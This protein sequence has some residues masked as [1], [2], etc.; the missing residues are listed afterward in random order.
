MARRAL[1]SAADML[2]WSHLLDSGLLV[3][4]DQQLLAGYWLAVPDAENRTDE[5]ADALSDHI[6]A[7]MTAFGTGWA[8]WSDALC[9]PSSAY[10]PAWLSHFPDGFS[11]A[12]DAARRR[13]FEAADAHYETARVLLI[14]YT[15]PREQVSKLGDLFFTG[16]P[17]QAPVQ[18]RIVQHFNGMLEKFENRVG[19]AIGMQR[20]RTIAVED[21]LGHPGRQDELVNY[22]SYCATGRVQGVLLPR[23]GA[24]MDLLIASQEVT[25]GENPLIGRDVVAAVSI[26]GFPAESQPNILAALGNLGFP[27][28][29]SQRFIYLDTKHAVDAI[30]KYRDRW[31]QKMRGLGA[32]IMQNPDAPVNEHAA[33]MKAQA[34]A[35][36]AWAESGMVKYG[37]YSP[38]VI[39]RHP[40]H[41]VL[42]EWTT[43]IEQAM[44]S[45]GFGARTET[46][47]TIEAWRGALPGETYCNVV[48]LP[49]HTKNAADLLPLSAIWSGYETA[50]SPLYPKGAPAL[51]WADAGV[52]PFRFNLPIGP[53]GDTAHTLTMGPTGAGKTVLHNLI[54]VQARRYRGMRITGFD[55]KRGMMATVLACGG[56]H[57]DL[58]DDSRRDGLFCPLGV[59]ETEADLEWAT[60][61][62]AVLYELHTDHPPGPDL[63]PQ[64]FEA[65]QSLANLHPRLRTMT[66]LVNTVLQNKAARRVFSFY[67]LEGPAGRYLDGVQDPDDDTDF[68]VYETQDLMQLGEKISLATLL[69]QFRRF[70]RTLKGQPSLLFL[71]EAWQV[72]GH[73]IWA[74]RLAKWLRVLRSKNAGIVMD[75]QS[76]ADA[77]NSPLF[78][79]LVENVPR[80]I[81]L[82]NPAAMQSTGDPRAPGP[83]ELYRQFGLNDRQIRIIQHAIPKR[84]YYVT[85]QDGCRKI[86]LGLSR[87]ELA[88]LGATSEPDV[89]GVIAARR[90]YGD[91]WLPEYLAERG[92]PYDQAFVLEAANA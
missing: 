39:V 36:S 33:A 85:G 57:F 12:V 27:Y 80:K 58:A 9:Y 61:Y 54:A 17:K 60:D 44:S 8:S 72:F 42:R 51:L 53:L 59:L 23:S 88:I 87:L 18:A 82:A 40:D 66:H 92:V 79:L 84:E 15:P 77:V 28:R 5:E 69:Y 19:A 75:T 70:E 22:C 74:A 24:H 73:P 34:D 50:P 55:Y 46:T 47:N 4:K 67:T 91:R 2:P 25:V 62:L 16:G 64:I 52:V 7:A 31:K 29:Y 76:L 89:L 21:A 20:M 13:H 65:V 71:A 3:T 14:C 6:N 83:L 32:L 45:A 86:S 10:P 41:Q 37:Y 38:V 48:A 43:Q 26:D 78:S 56:R 30:R 68:R 35:A 49:I 90:Q 11:R 1:R 81:F 63:H